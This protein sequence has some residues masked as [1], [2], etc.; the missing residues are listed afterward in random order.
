MPSPPVPTGR[1]APSSSPG[2][3]PKATT[4]MSPRRFALSAPMAPPSPTVPASPSFSFLL[5]PAPATSRTRKAAR[6][7]SPNSPTCFSTAL[8]SRSYLTSVAPARSAKRSSTRKIS[9]PK[10]LSHPTSL[11]SPVPSAFRASS[12]KLRRSPAPT[13]K[14]PKISSSIFPPKRS[15]AARRFTSRRSTAPVTS[16]IPSPPTSTL[17]PS[18]TQHTSNTRSIVIP[19]THSPLSFRGGCNQHPPRNLHWHSCLLCSR[20]HPCLQPAYLIEIY[21]PQTP[22]N[23]APICPVSLANSCLTKT[24]STTCS[25]NSP[26]TSIAPRKPWSPCSRT[27]PIP[28]P[29]P[30]KSKTSNTPTT[31]SLTI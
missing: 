26:T 24:A 4:I 29:P 7:P 12:A 5:T 21:W 13:S 28:P 6:P 10:T 1:K 11:T 9:A 17:A 27:T 20:F 3:I 25:W 2:T 23:G 19:A 15:T 8:L 30:T 18:P 16:P 14:S 22:W 31:P